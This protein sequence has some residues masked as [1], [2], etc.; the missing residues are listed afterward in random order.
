M[1][2]GSLLKLLPA[3]MKDLT[4]SGLFVIITAL[5]VGGDRPVPVFSSAVAKGADRAQ[6]VSFH[7][8]L[9]LPDTFF[10]WILM[11]RITFAF[12]PALYSK[13]SRRRQLNSP[14]TRLQ[15]MTAYLY[16]TA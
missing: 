12:T 13:E 10:R 14:A 4:T 16:V 6:P 5:L 3:L 1:T 9:S 15:N 8:S 2:R 11:H 7:V